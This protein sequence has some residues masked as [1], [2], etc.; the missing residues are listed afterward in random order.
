MMRSPRHALRLALAAC[1]LL[2]SGCTPFA[3]PAD[4]PAPVTRVWAPESSA[5]EIARWTRRE[6]RRLARNGRCVER[7]L[8]ALVGQVGIGRAMEVLDTL[9]RTDAGVRQGGHEL[10]HGMGLAAYRSPETLAET[11]AACPATHGGGCL[12]GV[13][14]GYFLS[15]MRQGHLPGTTELD[16]L[17]EP[18][19]PATFLFFQCAHATG[20]GLMAVH[21]NHVPRSLRACDLATDAFIREGCYGGVFM[22]N[23]VLVTH[24]H[25]TTEGHAATQ[26]GAHA[27][28]DAQAGHDA[29]GGHGQDEWKPVDADDPLYPCSV[30]DARYQPSCYVMQTS[31][32]MFLNGGDVQA[33]ARACETAREAMV[34]ICFGSLGRDLMA[35]AAQ[36]HRR[37]LRMC[38]QVAE[39]AGGRGGLWCMIGLVQNLVNLAADADEG[40]RFCREVTVDAHKQ[41]CYRAVGEIVYS[42]VSG[43]EERG[44]T[45]EGAEPG[46]VAACR[47]GAALDPPPA[48]SAGSN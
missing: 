35:L 39:M 3:R 2:L 19:R 48:A 38:G 5:A 12:H 11:F 46:F 28:H 43:D 32:T 33:T 47:R 1:A 34:P 23:I 40:M 42:L 21:A 14:Q 10:A 20:H 18:H 30:V 27:G 17:C 26:D 25:N 9:Q 24:P 29:P 41:A 7:N 45:C 22:E 8:V 36:D 44:R 15:L 31:A 37:S 6:C 4:G 16:A 13:V